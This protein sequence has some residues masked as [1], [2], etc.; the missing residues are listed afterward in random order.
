M[1][2]DVFQTSMLQNDLQDSSWDTKGNNNTEQVTVVL[3]SKV[4]TVLPN[5]FIGVGASPRTAAT[6]T[7]NEPTV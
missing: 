1:T 3:C 2:E 4:H 7:T 6:S 5:L